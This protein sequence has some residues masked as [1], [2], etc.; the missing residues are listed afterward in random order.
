MD[1]EEILNTMTAAGKAS[2]ASLIE[3]Y[4]KHGFGEEDIKFP[5]I[6]VDNVDATKSYSI[7]WLIQGLLDK[8]ESQQRTISAQQIDLTHKLER[9]REAKAR[10]DDLEDSLED[11]KLD[12]KA[13]KTMV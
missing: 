12:F 9:L 13:L 4:E 3:L 8:I 11:W 10:I 1:Q 7:S 6:F 5:P 2:R